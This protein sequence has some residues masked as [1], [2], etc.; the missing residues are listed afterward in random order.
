MVTLAEC[1]VVMGILMGKDFTGATSG[2][3]G[4]D[5]YTG[6]VRTC[7]SRGLGREV[8]DAEQPT[9]SDKVLG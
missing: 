9:V 4:E 2:L 7:I 8:R 6:M 3:R 5:Q 1:N